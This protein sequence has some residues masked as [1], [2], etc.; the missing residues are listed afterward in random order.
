MYGYVKSRNYRIADGKR[1]EGDVELAW[2]LLERVPKR[3]GKCF[4]ME[5]MPQDTGAED[6]AIR[7]GGAGPV[8]IDFGLGCY[9]AGRRAAW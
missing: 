5:R 3:E 9:R 8:E 7:I 2:S 1:F 6:R 4:G